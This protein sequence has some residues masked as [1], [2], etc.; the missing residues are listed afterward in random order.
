[1]RICAAKTNHVD[2]PAQAGWSISQWCKSVGICRQTFYN[3]PAELR[4]AS[5]KI[6]RRRI[7]GESP[8][9]YLR[10]IANLKVS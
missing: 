5:V 7:I 3:L 4:P 10:R 8:A 9:D 1:M 2:D 6:R